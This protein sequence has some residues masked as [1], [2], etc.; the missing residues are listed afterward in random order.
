MKRAFSDPC[1]SGT[2]VF[3]AGVLIG[4]AWL[5]RRAHEIAA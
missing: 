3:T 2:L 5:R 1:E 4:S